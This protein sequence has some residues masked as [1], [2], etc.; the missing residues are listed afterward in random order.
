MA[1]T[2]LHGTP[3]R[4]TAELACHVHE[5]LTAMLDGGEEGAFKDIFSDTG[6]GDEPGRR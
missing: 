1:E 6:K 3:Y 2:I 4:A 5:V